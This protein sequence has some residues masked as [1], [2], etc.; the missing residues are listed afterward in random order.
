MKVIFL[1]LAFPKMDKTKYLYTQLVSQFHENGHDITVVAPTYDDTIVGLQIEEGV[2]VIRVKTLPLFGVGLIKKG[3]ANVLLPYQYKSALKKNNIGLDFDLIITPTP[4][5]T[6][7]GVAAW[8]KKKSKGKLYLILRDIFPQNAVDLGMLKKSGPIHYYF[9]RKEKKLYAKADHIGCMSQ[10]N[11]DFV[12]KHNPSVSAD[13]LHML[14]NWGDII[15]L[16]QEEK[17]NE[18]RQQEGFQDKFVVIFGGNIGLPQKMEN[19]VNLAIA[20]KDE[21]DIVF[22]IIGRGNEQENLKNLIKSKNVKNMELRDGLPQKEYMKW[23]QMADVG[24]ISLSEKFTI[25]NIPS[26][27]LSYYN[28]KTP[29]L[30]SI[31][32]NTDFGT[33][34]DDLK[35]GVWAEAGNTLDLKKKLMLLYKDAVL[36]KE[37]GQNGFEYMKEYL[38]SE[39]ALNIVLKEAG[40]A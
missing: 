28:T 4:P 27:A 18:L 26:K 15:P 37:M 3:I 1:A 35:V 22:L 13:K 38:S 5:I 10:G 25:P 33:I 30:A 29:I 19:I 12:K 21:K 7:Y 2:K 24:L 34:L 8:L 32:L 11:I 17:I 31:D 39:T 40:L 6:L 20:C 14:S 16:A 36:R 23:V 9:R